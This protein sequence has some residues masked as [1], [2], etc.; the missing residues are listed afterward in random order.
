MPIIR[1][2]RA[3]AL[4]LALILVPVAAHAHAQTGVAGGLVSGFLHPLFGF[5]HLVAMVAVGLWGAQL[6]APAIWLLPI[7]FP[8]MMAVGAMLGIIGVPMLSVELGIA[9][10]AVV[11]GLLVLTRTRLPIWGAMGVVGAFA[12]F[13][14]HAH[15]T[16]LPGAADPLAYGIGFVTSTGL[17][18]LT[19][20]LLGLLIA[21][22]LGERA[23]RAFGG[24]VAAVGAWFLV[25]ALGMS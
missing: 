10:S 19:G 23:V 4:P 13:H 17:L 11:L 3:A 18:H 16:E 12:L 20:I 2:Y 24:V 6:G 9:L 21:W 25:G 7:T 22:P 5:D 1:D 8:L 14:G 15:G